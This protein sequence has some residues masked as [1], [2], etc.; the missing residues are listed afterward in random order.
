MRSRFRAGKALR[1]DGARVGDA[2]YVSGRLGKPWDRP[3]Q[4]RLELGRKLRGLATSCMDLSDG[5]S[6]D[7]HRLCVA[8]GVAAEM[9]RVPV[10]RGATVERALHGGEDYELLFT[11]P[12]GKR[13]P[14]G[15]R[16]SGASS[17][18]RA[19][20]TS[21]ISRWS[22]AAGIISNELDTLAFTFVLSSPVVA[23]TFIGV[24]CAFA[25]VW[26]TTFH[27]LT[28]RLV[29]FGGG[30]LV[31][32]ALFWVLPEMHTTLG[33]PMAFLWMFGGVALLAV[34]DRFVYPVCPSCSPAHDH[35]HCSGPRLHGFAMPL[36]MAS[37]LHSAL[38]GW[39]AAA[40]Q[41]DALLSAGFLLG[42][43]AHK[44]PEG[45]ALG[46]IA[47]A[48]MKSRGMALAWVAAA[49]GSTLIGAA[50]E[51]VAAPYLGATGLHALLALAG[52]SF[53]YLGY[54]AIHG[55]V[56]RRGAS[57]ALV[58]ALTGVAGS[59]VLRLLLR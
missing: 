25:G 19:A 41:D 44:I 39:S 11:L 30:T 34:V 12:P 48:S 3:I 47:R 2:L 32:V 21:N 51:S 37:A 13:A 5:L 56:R 23:I 45:L 55:E 28:R 43:A 42:I 18:A 57:P 27:D 50:V 59:T 53:L 52:G 10:V 20:S 7:L 4:P 17:R 16:S 8:S 46:V 58:P 26:L 36:L 29:P 14:A 35:E 22:R 54:H 33:W 38:D 1:R 15:R 40:S 9:D 6:L 24:L 31:G 49:Q